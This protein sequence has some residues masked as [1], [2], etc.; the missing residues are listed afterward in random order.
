MDKRNIFFAGLSALFVAISGG[1]QSALAQT[2]SSLAVLEEVVVTSQYREERLQDVPISI[3]V[4]SGESIQETGFT[5]MEAVTASMPSVTVTKTLGGDQIFIRGVGSGANPGFQQSVGTF[6]DGIYMGKGQ[7]SRAKFLDIERF[8]VLRGP[9]SIY[10]GNNTIA[11]ALNIITRKPGDELE[12]FVNTYIEPSDGEYNV[13]AAA[14]G[15]ISDTL[16]VRVAYSHTELKG[17][18]VNEA[19]GEDTPNQEGNTGRVVLAWNPNDLFDATLKADFGTFE[20]DGENAQIF[21]CPPPAP[22]GGGTSCSS[23]VFNTPGFEDDIDFK[24]QTGAIGAPAGTFFDEQRNDLDTTNYALTMNWQLGEHTLTSIT[25]YSAYDSLRLVDVDLGPRAILGAKRTEEFEQWSQELRLLSPTEGVISYIVGTYYQT[26]SFDS[27]LTQLRNYGVTAAFNQ[28][29]FQEADTW[30]VFGSLTWN[31]L[32]TVRTTLGLRYTKVE[33]DARHFQQRLS[34]DLSPASPAQ[35]G[36]LGGSG[37]DDHDFNNSRTDDNLTPSVNIQ[38]DVTDE[39]MLYASFTK[40]F[41]A[42]GFDPLVQNVSTNVPDGGFAFEPEEVDTIEIGAKTIL[43]DGSME[44]NLNLFRSEYENLQVTTFNPATTTFNVGNAG[45]SVTQGLEIDGSWLATTELTVKFSIAFLDAFYE[46]FDTATCTAL[47]SF[48]FGTGCVQDL[49]GDVLTYAPV[50]AGNFGLEYV[51]PVSADL[52][53]RTN[54][55][56]NFTDDFSTQTDNDPR[57]FT[58]AFEKVDLRVALA[59]AEGIWEVALVGRNITDELTSHFSADLPASEGA[60]LIY[61]DRPRTIALQ[62]KYNF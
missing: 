26:D 43:L 28:Q 2:D 24:L 40:G 58:D 52:E 62:A 9:Q 33:K 10:F 51:V 14:G 7:Q 57:Y 42:G 46:E 31:I 17:Y 6:I 59:D 8:E 11:G 13:E 60:S 56:V 4:L 20:Q 22:F 18:L 61:L 39:M 29:Y 44:L 1:S 34:I 38:W 45:K 41:K 48:N 49:S 53:L 15:P 19:T 23:A 55:T 32:D 50:Y 30:S 12:G 36:F 35:I 37:I 54:L 25:G 5:D 27:T 47:Q 3:S 21:D 16:G